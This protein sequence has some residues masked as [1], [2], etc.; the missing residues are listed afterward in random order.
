MKALYILPEDAEVREIE[1]SGTLREL[2][3]L[4]GGNIEVGGRTEGAW[5]FVAEDAK[6]KPQHRAGFLLSW[7]YGISVGKGIVVGE[8]TR[9]QDGYVH[10]DS[11]MSLEEL[12]C[13]ISWWG[14]VILPQRA[15]GPDCRM[16]G[17]DPS[18]SHDALA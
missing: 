6:M 18:A 14:V 3:L 11:R 2:E 17:D 12:R 16:E 8:E 10:L 5:L 15:G 4:V 7:G 13:D 1:W 9:T